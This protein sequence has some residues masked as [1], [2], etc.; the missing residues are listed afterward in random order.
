MESVIATMSPSWN[1]QYRSRK[2]IRWWPN[3]ELVRYIGKQFP[4]NLSRVATTRVLDIGCGTGANARFLLEE[5]FRVTAMDASSEAIAIA[6]KAL[7]SLPMSE[8]EER[9]ILDLPN[10]WMHCFDLAIDI[11]TIQ[12]TTYTQ[13]ERIYQEIYNVLKPGGAFFS[14]HMHEG[15]WDAKHG[16]GHEIDAYTFDNMSSP[17][18]LY[19]DNGIVCLLP[20]HTMKNLLERSGF[21]V[22]SIEH[23]V[24]TYKQRT[25]EAR[26]LITVA[27]KE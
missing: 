9:S 13:H 24:R 26:Y 15:H 7:A 6:K 21:I 4:E 23:L 10:E 8:I 20:G 14:V 11:Q 2:G 1:A 22:D 16:G 5:G 27:T 12:H 19:P 25:R 18:A 17:E 3:E